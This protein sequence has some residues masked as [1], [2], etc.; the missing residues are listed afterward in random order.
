MQA[1]LTVRFNDAV[2]LERNDK[3]GTGVCRATVLSNMLEVWD[4]KKVQQEDE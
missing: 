1:G 4:S 2:V 3:I